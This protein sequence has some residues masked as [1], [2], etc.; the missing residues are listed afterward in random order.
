MILQPGE[1]RVSDYRKSISTRSKLAAMGRDFD[2]D[3]DPALC[4]RLLDTE[5][6]DFVPP[7][8]DPKYLVLRRKAEHKEKTFGRREGAAKTVTTRGSDI[9]EAKRTRKIRAKHTSHRKNMEI[10][11]GLV[12]LTSPAVGSTTR[13]DWIFENLPTRSKIPSRPFQQ[14]KKK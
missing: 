13:K 4:N 5:T 9:G 12:I 11:S 10:K 3:H 14:R 6:G 7:Q 8:D 2:V 1:F